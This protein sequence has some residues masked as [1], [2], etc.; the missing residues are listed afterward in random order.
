MKGINRSIFK[1]YEC[2][3]L[4]EDNEYRFYITTIKT[5]YK[6]DKVV[7]EPIVR[8]TRSW[9]EAGNLFQSETLS[10]ELLEAEKSELIGNVYE[11]NVSE[12]SSQHRII[13]IKKLEELCSG[14]LV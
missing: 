3:K 10:R 11:L 6:G 13:S 1:V 2:S 14:T 8:I 4:M 5:T 9:K 12:V 7:E